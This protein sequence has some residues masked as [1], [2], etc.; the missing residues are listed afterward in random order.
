MQ[1][2]FD[3]LY[4]LTDGKAIVSSDVGQHQMWAAQYYLTDHPDNWLTSGG[5]GSMGFGFPAAI[6]AQFGRP[7][8]LVLAVVGD[9]GFQMTMAEL[10]TACIHKLPIKVVVLNNH[11]L[12]MVRQWQE[13]FYDE[14]ESGVNLEGNPDF[15]KLAQAFGALGLN[16]RRAGDVRK[17]LTKALE[18][19]DGPV[20]INAEVEK[21]DNVYPMV[22]SGQPLETMIVDRP[23]TKLAKPIGST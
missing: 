10:A 4:K 9:G 21:A 7:N 16:L 8:D 18:Y 3:E 22:P 6:G 13:L 2:V 12:G 17:V 19:Q 1:H 23:T 20:V 5:A 14:R 11:Y 15:A